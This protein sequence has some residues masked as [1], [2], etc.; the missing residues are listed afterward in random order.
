MAD[1]MLVV[2]HTSVY[3]P[4]Y[5]DTSTIKA[6]VNIARVPTLYGCSWSANA[7]TIGATTTIADIITF[8]DSGAARE[9]PWSSICE[10]LVAHGRTSPGGTVRNAASVAGNVMLAHAH[11]SD[12]KQ[13]PV[14]WPMLL[15]ALGA[16][17]LIVNAVDNSEILVE[18]HEF[19]DISM[20]WKYIK[21][22]VIPRPRDGLV[23]RSYAARQRNV[24]AEAYA[25]AAM[26]V[27]VRSCGS[28]EPGSARLVFNSVA[29]RPLRFSALEEKL[30]N[31]PAVTA[32]SSSGYFSELA[33][34]LA[35]E[36]KR[37]QIADLYGL[38]FGLFK[39]SLC[40]S[41]L[42]KFCLSMKPTLPPSLKLAER[43]WLD[44]IL[45]KAH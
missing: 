25:S 28:I 21:S 13:F 20:Q 5:T 18:F 37:V 16:R 41:F 15:E 29:N 7:L 36:L 31:A 44:N 38:E 12:G 34:L 2:G 30:E 35:K 26:S 40:E 23:F 33:A 11:Q 17:I 4:M 8:C 24:F 9:K 43:P 19:Y 10:W 39:H 27:V 3:L 1:L 32:P 42:Q 14:E 6:Y 45:L 22:F